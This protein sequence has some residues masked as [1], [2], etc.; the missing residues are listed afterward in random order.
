MGRTNDKSIELTAK[1]LDAVTGGKSGTPTHLPPR[2]PF[3]GRPTSV[4]RRPTCEPRP[5]PVGVRLVF[6]QSHRRSHCLKN[7]LHKQRAAILR[8]TTNCISKSKRVI[9]QD[10][11]TTD[12]TIASSKSRSD[13][14]DIDRGDEARGSPKCPSRLPDRPQ[15]PRPSQRPPRT[16]PTSAP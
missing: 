13:L 1:E 10:P 5:S 16:T 15:P 3:P 4:D 8:T 11:A 14:Q 7:S 2:N 6:A 12:G 9:S